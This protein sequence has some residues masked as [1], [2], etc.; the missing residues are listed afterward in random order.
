M[1]VKLD[2]IPDSPIEH[3]SWL[4]QGVIRRRDLFTL[5]GYAFIRNIA[6]EAAKNCD[7]LVPTNI[8]NGSFPLLQSLEIVFGGCFRNYERLLC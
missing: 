5:D 1:A 3:C 7:E 8:R 6:R 2:A 4:N